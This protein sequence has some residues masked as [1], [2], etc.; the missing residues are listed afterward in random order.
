MDTFTKVKKKKKKKKKK[1][2]LVYVRKLK[3]VNN[4]ILSLNGRYTPSLFVQDVCKRF[5]LIHDNN[6]ARIF[7]T[8]TSVLLLSVLKKINQW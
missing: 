4:K 7:D 2:V 8:L 6:Y 3:F 5:K 1:T